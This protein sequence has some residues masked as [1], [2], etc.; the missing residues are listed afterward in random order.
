[1]LNEKCLVLQWLTMMMF[2]SFSRETKKCPVKNEAVM[3][4]ECEHITYANRISTR[5]TMPTLK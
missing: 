3:R 2:F 4:R 5:C 1:M